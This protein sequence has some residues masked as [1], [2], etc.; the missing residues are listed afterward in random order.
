MMNQA[1][2]IERGDITRLAEDVWEAISDK[3]KRCLAHF[4]P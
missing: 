1:K 2:A 4:K 3:V